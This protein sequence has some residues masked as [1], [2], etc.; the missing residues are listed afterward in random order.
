M[1][2]LSFIFP[3]IFILGLYA[4]GADEKPKEPDPLSYF[5]GYKTI[6]TIKEDVVMRLEDF[7]QYTPEQILEKF[8]GKEITITGFKAFGTNGGVDTRY[9]MCDGQYMIDLP[10]D[11]TVDFSNYDLFI[12][13][14]YTLENINKYRDY[15]YKLPPLD[16]RFMEGIIAVPH[17]VCKHCPNDKTDG[18][19]P[20]PQCA[21]ERLT[22]RP[23]STFTVKI[24]GAYQNNNHKSRTLM[25]IP[26]GMRYLSYQ[27]N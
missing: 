7:K 24:W 23:N 20:D 15:Y 12:T 11:P 8:E 3:F 25:A 16:E 6:G 13:F 1:K 19:K 18:R 17:E 26:T 21:R 10:Y 2:K 4:C 9:N 22:Y 14:N 5:D 27:G